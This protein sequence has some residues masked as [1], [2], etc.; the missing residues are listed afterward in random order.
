MTLLSLALSALLIL[1]LLWLLLPFLKSATSTQQPSHRR[2][3]AAMALFVPLFSL[4]LYAWLGTPQFAEMQREKPP[5]PMITLVDKLEQKLAQNAQDL[6]GWL[7]LARSH[8]VTRNYAKAV[9]A[10][11][12]ALAL[13]PDNIQIALALADNLTLQNSGRIN[14]RARELLQSAYQRNP[15]DNTTLWMLGMA[16][17][18]AG[19]PREAARYW[20][21]LYAQLPENSEQRLEVAKLLST[22]EVADTPVAAPGSP[23][24]NVPEQTADPSL[25]IH[26]NMD[27]KWR[28]E[29]GEAAVFIYA[30]SAEGIPMPIAAKKLA[31]ANLP[32][33]VLLTPTD[34]LLPQRRLQDFSTL[35]IGIKITRGGLQNQQETLFQSEQ[36]TTQAREYAF[37]IK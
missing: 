32:A 27:S 31:L 25:R 3:I 11:E 1:A 13:A 26:L 19:L 14:E 20:Q 36:I 8:S 24:T 10:Y 12:K 2:V 6:Q 5:A 17:Q 7:L 30:K 23:P 21:T 37:F 15:H 33:T 29:W 9:A 34:E 22:L 28:Q 16:E 35:I 18:Q 4:G